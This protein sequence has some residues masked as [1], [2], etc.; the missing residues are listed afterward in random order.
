MII[1]E[2]G[3]KKIGALVPSVGTAGNSYCVIIFEHSFNKDIGDIKF[4]SYCSNIT[5]AREIC[6]R[7]F[8]RLYPDI[9]Y[10]GVGI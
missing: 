7:E 6:E 2:D 4:I 3:N 5:E 8:R 10:N 1:Y 9:P